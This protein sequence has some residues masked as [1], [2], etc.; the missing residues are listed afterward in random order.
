[1][2]NRLLRLRHDAIVGRDHEDGDVGHLRATGPHRGERLVTRSVEERDLP[3]VDVHLVGADV[4][5]DPAGLGRDDASVANRVEKRRLAV[6]DVTHDRYDRRTRLEG[7]LGV[8]ERLRLLLLVGGML[9]RHVAVQ[10]GCD[11]L[12]LLVAQRWVA[13]RI[14]VETHEELDELL[15]LDAERLGEVLDADAGL[16]G[17]RAG[18]RRRGRTRLAAAPSWRASRCSRADGRCAPWS[19]TTRGA[20]AAPPPP[21][22]RSGRFGL[23]PFAILGQSPGGADF[24]G[25][26]P[27]SV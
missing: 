26:L 9:D 10:L 6:I 21:R 2:G 17:D 25:P 8:V 18:C 24:A 14:S 11:E 15:Q 16:D 1:M 22:G 23:P 7:V 19:M 5:R 27:A 12:D 3:A 4:L 20:R 13:V